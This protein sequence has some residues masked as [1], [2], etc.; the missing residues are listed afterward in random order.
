MIETTAL[1][2]SAAGSSV[3]K[4]FTVPVDQSYQFILQFEFSSAEARLQDTI[5]G[6]NHRAE[7]DEAPELLADK[8]EYGRPIPIRVLIR[9]VK[10]QTVVI[11]KQFTSRCVLG[12]AD[13][14]KTRRIGSVNL[15]RGEYT[16][17]LINVSAQD[18]LSNIKT[19]IALVP[20]TGK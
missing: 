14:L 19:F 3:E 4:P 6:D 17:E 9:R 7:C 20:G 18:G 2:L 8:P 12:F 16:A 13:K 5:V 11:D 15:A 1:T 10:D